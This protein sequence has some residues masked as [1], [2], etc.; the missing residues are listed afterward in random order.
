MMSKLIAYALDFTSFLLQKV[1][2]GSK[3]KNV[4]LFGSVA[5]EEADTASDVDLFVDVTEESLALEKE[6]NSCLEKFMASAKYKSYWAL[7][8][9]KNPI[10]LKVGN[11]D[12]WKELKA[13]IIADGILLYGK[14]KS[15][16]KEGRHKS[17]FVWENVKPNSKRVLLNKQLFGY[18]HRR[19]FYDGLL[20]K[21][22]GERLGKGCIIVPLEYSTLFHKL[23]RKY[24][25]AV[26]IK[27]ILE[28]T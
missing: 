5:R 7:L 20:Q 9:A 19:R 22:S 14:F 17:L 15:E 21:H 24:K 1:K 3:I 23:F 12:N 18:K 25:I 4:I 28:Y 10:N 2:D 13:N 27:K 16:V 8:G 26:K 11:L 6:I